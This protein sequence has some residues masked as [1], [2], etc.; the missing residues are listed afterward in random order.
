MKPPVGARQASTD[1]GPLHIPHQD[2]IV[3]QIRAERAADTDA[4]RAVTTKAFAGIAHS[5]Q[6]EARIID[7]LRD[8]G[9]L[10]VSLIAVRKD[11]VIGHIAFSPVLI[12]E[13]VCDWYGLGPVSVVPELQ[14]LGI[15]A[16]L[17]RKGL[18]R[19]R[20]LGARG[21]VV[22]GDPRYYRRFGFVN[23][24]DLTYDGGPPEAFQ[25]LILELRQPRGAVTY[26][27]AFDVT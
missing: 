22:F 1:A 15:G 4:I 17:I 8:A 6:T 7:A 21:C 5:S 3:M 2:T 16:E 14:G 13:R 27:R 19:L 11:E 25:R 12:D 24:P 10:T 18:E 9:A 23:D 26:H 20:D